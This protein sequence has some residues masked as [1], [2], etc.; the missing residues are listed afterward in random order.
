[1]LG[2]RQ[3][4]NFTSI[5]W[6]NSI[7]RLCLY[8]MI[9]GRLLKGL[10]AQQN[11]C[12]VQTGGNG[13]GD[14]SS[15]CRTRQEHHLTFNPSNYKFV[16]FQ[17]KNRAAL[18]ICVCFCVSLHAVVSVCGNGSIWCLQKSLPFGSESVGLLWHT[19]KRRCWSLNK[20]LQKLNLNVK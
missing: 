15:S 12:I 5:W 10:A 4:T 9:K 13:T 8:G 17:A 18:Y 2:H 7:R 14:T 1:M 20:Q 11:I 16:I 3:N 19:M 6:Q